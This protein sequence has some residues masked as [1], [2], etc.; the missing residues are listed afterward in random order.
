MKANYKF[1]FFIT[2]LFSGGLISSCYEDSSTLD[3]NNIG[4]VEIKT[5][6]LSELS[7]YQ[8]EHLAVNPVVNITGLSESDLTYTWR[9]NLVP[10][11]T[12]FVVIGTEKNLNY[13]VRLKP[14]EDNYYYKLLLTVTNQANGL[15]YMMDWENNCKKSVGRRF[16]YR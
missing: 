7:V 8:F 16:G 5:P 1:L 13:E 12:A 6:G 9:I 14:N 2:L 4:N 15:D 10:N 3:I 11:D